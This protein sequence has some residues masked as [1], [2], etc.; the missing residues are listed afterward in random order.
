[1]AGA[2]AATVVV[3]AD[4]VITADAAK[5]VTKPEPNFETKGAGPKP[6]PFSCFSLAIG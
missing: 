3:A 6:A 4:V 5:I 2:K 1:V